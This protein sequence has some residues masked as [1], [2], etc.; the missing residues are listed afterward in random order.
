MKGDPNPPPDADSGGRTGG[1]R[2]VDLAG[3]EGTG[4]Q[5]TVS[6]QTVPLL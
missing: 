2:S 4:P 5:G 1:T 6:L 3:G